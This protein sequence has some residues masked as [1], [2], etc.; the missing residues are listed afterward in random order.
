MDRLELAKWLHENYEAIA[1]DKNW[2]T[3]ENCKV[4]FDT[5]PPQNKLTMLELADRLLKFDLL[6]LYFVSGSVC[7]CKYRIG[8][9]K[10]WCCNICGV[11]CEEF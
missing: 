10:L 6:R 4:D 2:N 8:E 5:L 11:R 1:K 3:Q 7:Q 9:T